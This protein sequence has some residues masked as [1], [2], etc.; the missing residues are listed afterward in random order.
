MALTVGFRKIE[1]LPVVTVS[2]R[3]VDVDVKKLARK[4]ESVYKRKAGRIVVD[5]SGTDFIDSHGLGTIVYFHTLMQK[6]NRELVI[7]NANP[8][9]NS[10]IARLFELTHLN[11]VLRIVNSDRSLREVSPRPVPKA[12]GVDLQ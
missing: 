11:K 12:G 5:I 8:D 1:N 9:P 2:G 7:L 3:A 10:Y 4:L 6:Q